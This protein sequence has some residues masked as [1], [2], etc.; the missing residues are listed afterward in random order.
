MSPSVLYGLAGVGLFALGL[1]GLLAYAPV[2]R[3]VLAANVASVG[4]FMI[5]VA[6]AFR[7]PPAMPDPVPHAMV[8]TGIVVAVSATALALFLLCRLA[9]A[10]GRATLPEDDI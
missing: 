5:L 1:Y 9:L 8:L 6:S 10:T 3:K 4:V 2:L 7:A